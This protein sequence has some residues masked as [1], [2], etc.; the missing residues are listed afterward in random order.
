MS[1]RYWL[2]FLKMTLATSVVAYLLGV[3]FN[4]FSG[5][6]YGEFHPWREAWIAVVVYYV[7]A[8]GIG[9]VNALGV[10]VYLVLDKGSD[11]ENLIVEDLR[12]SEIPA[13]KQWQPSRLD[14]LCM[15]ADDEE[16]IPANRVKA[17]AL[18]AMYTQVM[19]TAGFFKSIAFASAADRAVLRYSAEAPKGR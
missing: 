8:I 7:C 12:K 15:M 13:P 2:S 17:A 10:I 11:I 6:G 4:Y 3:G 5:P 19:K 1:K 18:Y 14:Y 9:I 16:E